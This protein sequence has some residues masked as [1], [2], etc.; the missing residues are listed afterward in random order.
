M[1]PAAY[2][3]TP[4]DDERF[5]FATPN[6]I[7]RLFMLIILLLSMLMIPLTGCGPL[8]TTTGSE[9]E[10]TVPSTIPSDSGTDV[11]A[12]PTATNPS[13]TYP[14]VHFRSVLG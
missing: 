12:G 2:S 4:K 9:S 13:G 11:T 14:T 7:L 8:S 1:M 5:A 10:S 3:P 6:R